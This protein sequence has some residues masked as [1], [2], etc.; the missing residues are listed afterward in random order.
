MSWEQAWKE[1]RTPWDAGA[2]PPVLAQL[3]RSGTLPT[4]RALVPGCGAG[5][6]VLTLASPERVAIGVDLAPTAA[7]R[8]EQLRAQRGIPASQ[9]RYEVVDFFEYAPEAP[10]D[11]IWDYTFLCALD[12]RQRDAWADRMDRLLAVDGELLTLIFP[13]VDRSPDQGPPYP[14]TPRLVQELLAGRFEATELQ[15][16]ATSHSSRLGKEWLGR[17][18]RPPGR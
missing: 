5:Y 18:R 17:W 3:V 12:P 7:A 14:M 4:G 10:F 9:A 2:S 8:F 6:D 13:V 16:V 15:P 1:A 11:L